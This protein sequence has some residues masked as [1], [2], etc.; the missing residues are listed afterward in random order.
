MRIPT[1]INEREIPKLISEFISI[2]GWQ[3]W[4]KRT[5]SLLGQI[6][7]NQLLKVY[8]D[9]KFAFE[10][11]LS[12]LRKRRQKTN[13]YDFDLNNEKQYKLF[14]FV[15]M[16]VGVHRHLPSQA[17]KRLGGMIRGQLKDDSGLAPVASEMAVATHL[18]SRE[19]DVE[20]NDLETGGGF[21]FLA[22]RE[23]VEIEV[24]CKHISGDIGRKI[25]KRRVY[26]LGGLIVPS[27]DE[28]LE[29]QPDGWLL[30]I[31][32]P[33]RLTG[34][35]EQH[36]AIA[37]VVEETLR[38][39]QQSSDHSVCSLEVQR[40]PL[41]DSP[42]SANSP[43]AISERAMKDFVEKRLGVSNKHLFC[44]FEPQKGAVVV[45]VHS[46]KPDKVLTGIYRQ[47]KDSSRDQLT[48][49][50]PGLMCVHLED[51]SGTDLI[52]LANSEGSDPSNGTGLQAMATTV[53][54]KRPQVHTV[55]FTAAGDIKFGS[56]VFENRVEKHRQ[57]KGSAYSF[58]NPNHPLADDP[59]YKVF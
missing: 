3:N 40:F 20:F 2:V 27:L 25:H 49:S 57:E 55:A 35:R 7:K 9:E 1:E 24:E 44:L 33:D 5:D 46:S 52:D 53:L 17:Q 15:A 16:V 32:V 11:E 38:S 10:L 43:G 19:F 28:V 34:A 8:F 31:T 23:G 4:K 13:K 6:K 56:Q 47:I 18:M 12:R 42:F 30:T 29:R 21:D 48:G 45:V 36:E 58:P 39:G 59:L 54:L 14:S 26:E 37:K 51:V 22:K 41:A 50:R